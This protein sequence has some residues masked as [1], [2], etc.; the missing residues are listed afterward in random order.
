V[1]SRVTVDN[2]VRRTKVRR[3]TLKRAPR[4][5]ANARG[6]ESVAAPKASIV[7]S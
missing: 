5:L 2:D 6:S 7:K 4:P 3:G 1:V